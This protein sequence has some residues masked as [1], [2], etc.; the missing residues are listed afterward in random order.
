MEENAFNICEIEKIIKDSAG[1]TSIQEYY[2]RL[3]DQLSSLRPSDQDSL[4]RHIF[5]WMT[6][7]ERLLSFDE[8]I[9]AFTFD[10]HER[11]FDSYRLPIGDDYEGKIVRGNCAN[12]IKPILKHGIIVPPEFR[13]ANSKPL[14]H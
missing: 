8:V 11:N 14:Q 1:C 9:F 12:L 7:S 3:F 5:L 2:S 4:A 10:P 13:S 6:Y